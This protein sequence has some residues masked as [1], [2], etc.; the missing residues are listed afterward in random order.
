MQTVHHDIWDYDVPSQPALVDL[1]DGHG[2]TVPA[3]LQTTKRGQLF[4]LN[5]A[6]GEAISRIVERPVPQNGAV[7]EERLSPT[8]PYS[9]DMPA[10]GGGA[11]RGTER[12]GNDDARSALVPHLVQAAP[13]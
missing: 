5:R 4:L 12:M 3:L 10:I 1:P 9:V 8:Q 6:T 7:P 11:P 2:G 13:L